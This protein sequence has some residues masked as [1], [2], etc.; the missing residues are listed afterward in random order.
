MRQSKIAIGSGGLTGKGLGKG[1]QSQL[2]FVPEVHT[3]FIFA[4]LSEEVGFLGGG[5]ILILF[6]LLLLRILSIAGEAADRTGILLAAGVAALIFL[7]MLTNVGMTL[8]VLPA[9]GVPLPFV[10]YGGSS[11]LTMFAAVGMVINVRT[12]RFLY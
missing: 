11:T 6:G 2:G 7:H 8:G 1:L 3:D 12:R 10:S 9:I 5:A 4:L